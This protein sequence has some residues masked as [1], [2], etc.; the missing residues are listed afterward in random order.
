MKNRACFGNISLVFSLMVFS[1]TGCSTTPAVKYYT[2][3]PSFEMQRDISQSV[4]GDTLAIGVGPVE[5]PKFLDRPQIVT[6]KSQNRLEVS[7]FHRWAGS[8]SEDFLRVLSRNISVLLPADRVAAYPWTDQFSPTYGIQLTVEQFDGRFGGYVL[9]NV[10]WSVWNLEDA[11]ELVIKN[12]LIKEP[13][14]DEDY[15]SLV[16]AQSRALATLRRDIAM[17][18][19]AVSQKNGGSSGK[20]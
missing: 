7:E 5:F 2:L 19:K 17:A 18:I 6:R 9:L 4:S 12:T 14:S 20:Q 3:N 10:T 13:V 1:F 11:N 8:F 15:E 16:A